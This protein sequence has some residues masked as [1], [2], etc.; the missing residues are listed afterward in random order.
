MKKT[1]IIF[2]LFFCNNLYA[3]LSG[4]IILCKQYNL[5]VDLLSKNKNQTIYS[6]EKINKILKEL[7]HIGI[8]FNSTSSAIS[9]NL[10]EEKIKIK[11]LDYEEDDFIIFLKEKDK[12]LDNNLTI[13]GSYYGRIKRQSL[14]LESMG[15]NGFCELIENE[16]S[17]KNKMD[18]LLL[19]KKKYFE[20]KRK[21]NKI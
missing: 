1:L 11:K 8:V 9:Y 10:F 7:P 12:K 14:H 15:F 13:S 19:E 17:L 2:V 20:S 6:D 18:I 5:A 3:D 16:Q 21:K 4:K